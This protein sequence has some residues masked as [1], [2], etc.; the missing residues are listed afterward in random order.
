[1]SDRRNFLK[2]LAAVLSAPFTA[3][4]VPADV[5]A[6]TLSLYGRHTPPPQVTH[7]IAEGHLTST[8]EVEG[9]L[10]LVRGDYWLDISTGT[11]YQYNGEIWEVAN[12]PALV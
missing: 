7:H 6:P 12:E 9:P 5:M 11:Y 4:I 10:A 2:G 8:H 3:V 1:M